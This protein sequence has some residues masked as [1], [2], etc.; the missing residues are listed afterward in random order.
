MQNGTPQEVEELKKLEEANNLIQALIEKLK[1][2]RASN[3]QR[4]K[5]A[6]IQNK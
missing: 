3:R 2:D 4:E 5:D 1:K 6:Y